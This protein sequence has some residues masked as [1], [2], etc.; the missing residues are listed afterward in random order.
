MKYLTLSSAILLSGCSPF[1]GLFNSDPEVPQVTPIEI[2][3]LTERAPQ[4]HPPLP[5][6]VS[7]AEIEWV[8]LNPTVMREYIAELDAQSAPQVAYYSLTSQAYEN[9]SN[10]LAD[11]RRYIRQT[12]NIIQYYRENDPT[13]DQEEE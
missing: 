1:S 7:P 9:L 13:R 5:E 3:T 2:V 12:L 4:Y 11:I 8:V 10:N 6:A